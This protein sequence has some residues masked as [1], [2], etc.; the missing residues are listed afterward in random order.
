MMRLKFHEGERICKNCLT[1]T[2]DKVYHILNGHKLM[3]LH[4]SMRHN[5]RGDVLEDAIILITKIKKIYIKIVCDIN[6]LRR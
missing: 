3:L 5:L 4:S 6:N 2:Q 1:D